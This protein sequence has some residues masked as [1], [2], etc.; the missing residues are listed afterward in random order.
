MGAPKTPSTTTTTSKVELGPEQKEVFNYAQPHIKAYAEGNQQLYPGSGIAGLDPGEQLAQQ[1][2]EQV[3]APTTAGLA[4]Q[5]ANAQSLLMNPDFML[6]PNQ[7]VGN[8]ADAVTRKTTQNLMENI[9]PGIRSGSIGGAGMYGANTRQGIAEGKAIG[10]T[11]Q[12]ISDAIAQMYLQNYQTGLSGMAQATQGNQ[13]IMAQQLFPA[14]IIAATGAQRRAGEQAK[15]D[16]E[17]ARFYAQ[18]DMPL[19]KSQQLLNLISGMPGGTGTTTMQG[20]MPK[21]NPLMSMLGLGTSLM[22][23]LGG[24]PLGMLGGMGGMGM[25]M[26]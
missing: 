25:G 17:I 22:G 15:L 13:N 18:Q 5:S 7:Y 19:L 3:A 1:Y 12:N 23:M 8:A 4:G 26:K 2:Y 20:A 10:D 14:N 24:G 6:N 11:G 21:T 9:L 16:E